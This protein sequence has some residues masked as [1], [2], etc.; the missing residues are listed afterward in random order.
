M[1]KCLFLPWLTTLQ[2]AHAPS[3]T[4][5]PY[6]GT[7]MKTESPGHPPQLFGAY[8]LPNILMC[9]WIFHE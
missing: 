6:I 3:R 8:V 1:A 5:A 4:R 7:C 2:D 9:K